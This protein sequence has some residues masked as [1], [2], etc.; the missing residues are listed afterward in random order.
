MD[1]LIP[2]YRDFDE[3]EAARLA[4][5]SPLEQLLLMDSELANYVHLPRYLGP[6][7]PVDLPHMRAAYDDKFSMFIEE[8]LNGLIEQPGRYANRSGFSDFREGVAELN[9]KLASNQNTTIDALSESAE[10]L[11]TKRLRRAGLDPT[12]MELDH[13]N[14]DG[15]LYIL[16]LYA[17]AAQQ[18]LFGETALLTELQT[19]IDEYRETDYSDLVDSLRYPV[20]M[21]TLWRNQREGLKE[22]LESERTGVLEMATATGKTVAGIGAIAHLCGVIPNHDFDVWGGE[23]R[24][25]DASIAVVA[26]SNAILSQWEREIRELLGLNVSGADRSGQPDEL[27]FATGAIDFH[28]IH[29]LQPRYGGAP[30]KTYDLVICDEAHHYSNTSEGG[31]GDALESIQTKA[32]LGL[33]ATLGRDGSKKR[34]A[35]ESLLGDVVYSYSVEDAQR[36]GIIPDFEWTVH[37]TAMEA[38]E[39][40]EWEEKTN[41]IT[42][43]FKHVRYSDRT[44]QILHNLDVPFVELEDLGDFIRAH[45]AASVERDSVPDDWENLHAAIMSRNMIRHRSRPKLDAAIDLAEEYLTADGDGIKVVMFAMDIATTE[46]IGKRLGKAIG[47]DDVFVVH[48]QVESSNKKK[49]ETVRSRIDQFKSANNGVLIAPKLLDEGIDV[50][51][52]EIGINVAGT[53]T[54]L[55]LIQRMGRVLRRYGDQRPHFHHY[56]AVPDEL[57]LDGVD[58]KE[59]A[60]QLYWVRELGERIG[61]QPAFEP[62]AV[63]EEVV[64]RAKRRGNE[65]WAEELMEEEDAESI[66]GPLNLQEILNSLSIPAADALLAT[67]HFDRTSLSEQEWERGMQAIRE[68]SLLAPSDIQQLWWL[69]P[70]YQDDATKLKRL[71][72]AAREKQADNSLSLGSSSSGSD[73]GGSESGAGQAGGS[74]STGD[75]RDSGTSGRNPTRNEPDVNPTRKDRMDHN[76]SDTDLQRL[77]DIADLEPTKNSELCAKWG[78][79]SGSDLYGYL[80]R[81]LL[82]YFDRNDNRKITLN[83]AGEKLVSLTERP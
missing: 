8:R 47:K 25:S 77:H 4:N 18:E 21:V 35:I 23:E 49:D 50:P 68:D 32:M 43:L 54:E 71:L 29:S 12:Q 40:D 64:K 82:D 55:Q 3:Y 27:S 11:L 20:L 72:T 75:G 10:R 56:V 28:T 1:P 9:K 42:N 53:K 14:R 62:A 6:I 70:I 26:H 19:A 39:A 58:G 33:S 76:L 31:F 65:L 66:D 80:R 83:E 15:A 73:S 22:W 36:D 60:K 81:S 78:Y 48:S 2:E 69:Y 67:V 17:T 38:S 16:E 41:R 74:G 37:P 61:Q 5:K 34:N 7:Y 46:E 63:D 51:D 44:K 57:H 45:K 52:A 30:D 79:D 13:M 24:T 59:F